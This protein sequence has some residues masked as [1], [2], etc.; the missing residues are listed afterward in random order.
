MDTRGGRLHNK[1]ER[2]TEIYLQGQTS[3]H[4]PDLTFAPLRMRAV[5]H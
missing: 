2:A 3:M 4:T 5:G 1:E